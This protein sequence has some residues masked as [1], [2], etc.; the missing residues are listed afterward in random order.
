MI[1]TIKN[2]YTPKECKQIIKNSSGFE[3]SYSVGADGKPKKDSYRFAHIGKSK[4]LRMEDVAKEVLDFNSKNRNMNLNG[5]FQSAVNKYTKGMYFNTHIDL[6]SGKGMLDVKECRKVSC[7][8]QL[9]NPKDYIGGRLMFE[10]KEMSA[11][12]GDFHIFYADYPHKV[13]EIT[14]GI[15]YSMNIFCYG[16]IVW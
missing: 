11:D 14:K 4:P 15:R 16:D 13:T 12:W 10:D 1:H 6:I 8:I 3:D 5:H 7:V 2:F 9:S